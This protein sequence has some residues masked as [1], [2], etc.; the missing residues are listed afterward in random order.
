MDDYFNR[1]LQQINREITRL[2]TSSQKSGGIVP[3]V[4]KTLR[5]TE[6]LQFT[7]LPTPTSTV[8]AIV[9]YKILPSS[10]AL[11]IATL[12]KYY[13]DIFNVIDNGTRSRSVSMSEE[14]NGDTIMSVML[15]GDNNDA[16][17]M[18]DGG[19][20][21]MSTEVTVRCTDNFTIERV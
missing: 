19:S 5:I 18:Y 3:T 14:R 4:S 13:D 10:T 21:S 8:R 16:R 9:K 2:K 7:G 1:E 6:Q 12:D 15:T 17:T 20:V 11:I